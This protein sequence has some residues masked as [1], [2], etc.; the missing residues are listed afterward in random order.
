V[1]QPKK[2]CHPGLE[3][4]SLRLQLMLYMRSFPLA[5]VLLNLQST[6]F[7]SSKILAQGRD[8]NGYYWR[9]KGFST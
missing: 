8:D 2:T 4:G 5:A 6:F 3:P 1:I 7:V 9:G